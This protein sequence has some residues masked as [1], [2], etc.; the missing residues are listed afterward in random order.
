MDKLLSLILTRSH[1][2]RPVIYLQFTIANARVISAVKLWKW[3]NFDDAPCLCFLKIHRTWSRWCYNTG[4]EALF[5]WLTAWKSFQNGWWDYSDN[6]ILLWWRILRSGTNWWCWNEIG[7][8]HDLLNRTDYF[9]WPTRSWSKDGQVSWKSPIPE[10]S[11]IGAKEGSQG[12]GQT[13][14]GTE[15]RADH[16]LVR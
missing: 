8:N 5:A 11:F 10:L 7:Q 9:G 15:D 3:P 2:L 12:I 14:P 16:V 4:W 13:N 1:A 6:E